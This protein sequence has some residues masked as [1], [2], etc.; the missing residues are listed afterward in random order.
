LPTFAGISVGVRYSGI[1]GTPYSMIV[2]GN[3]NGDFVATNDLAFVFD[4]ND[5]TVP[6][7]VRTN[8]QAILDNPLVN[9]GFKDY[10]NK[11]MGKVAERN[12]GINSFNG[13]WDIRVAKRFKVY[14]KQ[15]VELSGDVFNFGNL[16]KKK[17]GVNEVLGTQA[18]YSIVGFNA[19]T[20]S[21]NYVVNPNAGIVIPSGNPYQIQ[22]GLRYGF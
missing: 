2:A 10:L 21:Y 15:Y 17:W 14:K 20:N 12:G 1:G 5:V 16:L 19:A 6:A 7:A 8:I 22:L 3:V 18:L 4:P 9:Q 11:S 13:Q